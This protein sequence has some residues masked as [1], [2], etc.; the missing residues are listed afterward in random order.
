MKR[1]IVLIISTLT[2]VVSFAQTDAYKVFVSNAESK[3][4]DFTYSYSTGLETRM[5]GKGR[6]LVQ[7]DCFYLTGNELEIYCDGK[8]AA[9][10]DR[11]AK[12]VILEAVDGEDQG[13]YVNPALLVSSVSKQFKC[14]SQK[15]ENYSGKPAVKVVLEPRRSLNV[16]RITLHLSI[17][18]MALLAASMTM[19]DGTVSD[20]VISSF[21][22]LPKGSVGD[23]RLDTKSLGKGYIITDLR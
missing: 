19:D 2:S 18:G 21:R 8:T 13:N 4:A 12:E 1:L 15:T 14:T 10:L 11:T 20:F 9:T 6:V 5:T 23:F 17:D 3:R 7:D 22:F 16:L